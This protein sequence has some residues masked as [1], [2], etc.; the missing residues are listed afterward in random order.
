MSNCD[1]CE[2]YNQEKHCCPTY[3]EV[4]RNSCEEDKRRG[5]FVLDFYGFGSCGWLRRSNEGMIL[6]FIGC[7]AIGYVIGKV[8]LALY[9]RR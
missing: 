7:V 4:I 8:L 2:N 9:E 5:L 3:C 6:K 1:N